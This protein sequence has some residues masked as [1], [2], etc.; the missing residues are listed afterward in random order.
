M[1]EVIH[2]VKKSRIFLQ[3][4]SIAPLPCI[5]NPAL[6]S[7]MNECFTMGKIPNLE[8]M[9]RHVSV[10]GLRKLLL[11]LPIHSSSERVGGL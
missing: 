10:S 1:L 3:N 7:L 8:I 9:G 4:S 6:L 11:A 2:I 5:L